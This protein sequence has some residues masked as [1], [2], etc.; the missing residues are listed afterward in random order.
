MITIDPC[1]V[2]F[3][4]LVSPAPARERNGFYKRTYLITFKQSQASY[5]LGH[6]LMVRSKLPPLL[7]V[8]KGLHTNRH[9]G[10]IEYVVLVLLI[11]LT[12]CLTKQFKEGSTG[13]HSLR[14]RST[15]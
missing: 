8:Q 11:A 13:A 1:Q 4:N 10:D 5:H 7:T 14:V 2:G 6:I 12:K 3:P 15:M 9:V